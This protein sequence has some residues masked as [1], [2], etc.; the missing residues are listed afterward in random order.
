MPRGSTPLACRLNRCHA[1]AELVVVGG[2]IGTRVHAPMAGRTKPDHER[3]VIRT[4]VADAPKMVRLE[5]RRPVRAKKWCRR[6]TPLAPTLRARQHIGSHVSAALE[7]GA[8][9]STCGNRRPRG[10]QRAEP[11]VVEVGRGDLR[12]VLGLMG[13]GIEAP[14]FEDKRAS[15]RPLT[16]RRWLVVP[17][18]TNPLSFVLQRAVTLLSEEKKVAAVGRVKGNRAIAFDQLHVAD[19][20]FAEVLESPIGVHSIGVTVLLSFLARDHD[21]ERVLLWRDDPALSLSVIA[22]VDVGAAV[23][24]LPKLKWPSHRRAP[25]AVSTMLSA[26]EGGGKRA[27]GWRNLRGR[28]LQR[29][30]RLAEAAA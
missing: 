8:G 21:D 27:I 4:A 7:N 25:L 20:P 28:Q 12:C 15:D 29:P 26:A 6:S 14:Q 18:F 11:Q 10:I 24:R 16:V 5:V 1:L 22:S 3:G 30:C 23:V 19:L 17:A 9:A 13:D 2:T